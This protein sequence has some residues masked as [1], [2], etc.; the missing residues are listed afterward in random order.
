M[1]WR[2]RCRGVFAARIRCAHT[3]S[4]VGSFISFA[5]ALS[6]VSVRQ[7]ALI[8]ATRSA[9]WGGRMRSG[10]AL[11]SETVMACSRPTPAVMRPPRL[12]VHDSIASSLAMVFTD[13][14]LASSAGRPIT[15]AGMTTSAM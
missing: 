10:G 13:A 3:T 12:R 4:T 2:D 7:R 11:V 14:G 6:A 5:N 1:R 9:S 15:A 8:R